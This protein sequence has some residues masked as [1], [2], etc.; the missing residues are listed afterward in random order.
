VFLK[1]TSLEVLVVIMGDSGSNQEVKHGFKD[2]FIALSKPDPEYAAVF[3]ISK[4]TPRM[5]N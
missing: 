4:P 1:A 3:F 2:E 5:S